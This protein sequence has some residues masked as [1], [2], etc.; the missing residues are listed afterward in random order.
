MH[1]PNADEPTGG[2]GLARILM[3]DDDKDILKLGQKLLTH[4]GHIVVCAEDALK[5]M[6]LLDRLQFDLMI[7]DANMPHYSGFDLV[8]TVRKQ[9]IH[10]NMSITM[11]TGRREK[12]D[13]ENAV[14][15]GVDDYIV[16]PIDPMLF[17]EKVEAL[18]TKKPP[19]KHLELN[20]AEYKL[21]TDGLLQLNTQ[22][23][24]VS[25][26]GIEVLCSSTLQIG[27]VIELRAEAF[28]EIGI[29]PPPLRVLSC[30]ATQAGYQCQLLFLG[31]TETVLQKIRRWIYSHGSNHVN[32]EA[33]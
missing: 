20:L 4:A 25:E 1:S 31:A 6:Q 30:E 22:I 5:A 16:K 14:K 27:D 29:A 7:S 17:L 13:I 8:K 28:D 12:R 3:V 15:S 33:I 9:P 2:V 26:M 10:K 32:K 19:Q 23:L 18:F 11:L 24:K 21:K